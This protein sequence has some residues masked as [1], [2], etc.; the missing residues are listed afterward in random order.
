MRHAGDSDGEL[1][2]LLLCVEDSFALDGRGLV[3]VPDV[4][5]PPSG[6][7]PALAVIVE[8]PNGTRLLAD[9]ELRLDHF[10][11]GGYKRIICLPALNKADVPVGSKVW[12][13]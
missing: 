9:A 8:R 10:R 2:E 6:H 4:R 1:M 11:P 3:L 7:P 12:K 5:L 13:A